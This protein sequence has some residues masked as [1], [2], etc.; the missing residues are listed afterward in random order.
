V[1]CVQAAG[2]DHAHD[3]PFYELLNLKIADQL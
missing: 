1:N 2:R 3:V